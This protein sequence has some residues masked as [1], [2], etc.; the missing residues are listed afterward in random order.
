MR[1]ADL[2]QMLS[3]ISAPLEPWHGVDH[4]TVGPKT[5]R[6]VREKANAAAMSGISGICVRVDRWVPEGFILAVKDGRIVAIC[7][8]DGWHKTPE[9]ATKLPPETSEE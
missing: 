7:G 8:R 9:L 5:W 6:V 4:Y 1:L 3:D 2:E